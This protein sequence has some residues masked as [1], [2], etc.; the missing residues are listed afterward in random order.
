M[1]LAALVMKNIYSFNSKLKKNIFDQE[2]GQ[3]RDMA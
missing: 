2:K 1:I 3:N